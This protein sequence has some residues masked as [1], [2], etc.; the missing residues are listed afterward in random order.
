MRE[1]IIEILVDWDYTYTEAGNVI[2][3][4]GFNDKLDAL[5]NARIIMDTHM[6]DLD[7]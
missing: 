4:Y 3:K 5:S 1:N 6:E 2:D 7:S